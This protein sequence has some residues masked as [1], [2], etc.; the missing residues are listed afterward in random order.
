MEITRK[1]II[2]LLGDGRDD[3]LAGIFEIRNYPPNFTF[4]PH[5]HNDIE[6][7]FV[8]KGHCCM[9]F[10][11]QKVH[12]KKTDCM[13]IY[14]DVEHYFTVGN[15][16]AS[17]VQLEFRMDIFPELSPEPEMEKSLVFLYNL[18][19]NSQQYL[20]IINNQQINHLINFSVR[21]LQSQRDNYST[22][23]RLL[24]AQLFILISRHIKE[25]LKIT[26][27]SNHPLLTEAVEFINNHFSENITIQHVAERLDIS[28]RYLRRVFKNCANLSPLEY[29]NQLRINK[30]K[31]L[32]LNENLSVKDIAYMVGF[33]NPQYFA[34]RFKNNS[35][36]TPSEFRK[37]HALKY[38]NL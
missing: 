38:K 24:Y 27:S 25:T 37:K 23:I 19:T 12:F 8:T 22:M 1:Q 18:L 17:L 10:A 28:E 26:Q 32:L 35:G 34:R 29:L 6:M 9:Q 36:I 31:E 14:P 33:S 20:K 21:E 30:T 4:G 13:V 11:D 3:E 2:N 16:P 7:N 5:S 15:K